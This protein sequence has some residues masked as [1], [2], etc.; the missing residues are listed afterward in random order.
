MLK[1]DIKMDFTIRQNGTKLM[2]SKD[3]SVSEAMK[4]IDTLMVKKIGGTYKGNSF[5]LASMAFY[6]YGLVYLLEIKNYLGL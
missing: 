5:C 2:K 6:G 1:N 4:R 3:I